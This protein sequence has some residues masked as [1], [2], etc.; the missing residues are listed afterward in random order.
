M[1]APN[2]AAKRMTNME[3]GM[4]MKDEGKLF[5]RDGILYPTI[6][7]PPENLDALKDLQAREDDVMLVA[8]PKCGCNWM[9]GVMRKIL[10]ACGY[11]FP[12]RPHIFEFH[13][14]DIQKLAARMPPRRFFATHLHPDI[15]PVSFKTNKTKMLVMFR[16]PKDTVVSYFHFMNN[17]PVL[18]KAES[19][20]KFFSDFMSGEV[21]WG[22]YFDHALAWEKHMDDPN[23]LVV[24]Y[25]ELKENLPEGVKKVADFFSFPLT[26]EQVEAIAGESTFSAMRTSSENSHGK[27]GK[28]FFRK[29]EVGDWKKHFSEAQSKQM[30]EEFKKKLS[31]TRLGAKLKYEQYCQ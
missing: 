25:E 23:V 21:A 6:I 1:S 31:G 19:W 5:K 10:T 18:P 28:V 9:V 11:T 8:Y 27:F 30:D 24:T 17:N 22:S 13:S 12:D 29:G 15:I 26:N 4:N 14:P 16:N 20:D 2:F 3:R 7:S